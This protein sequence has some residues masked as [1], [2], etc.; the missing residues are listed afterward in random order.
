MSEPFIFI[1]TNRIKEGKLEVFKQHHE[2][3]VELVEANEPR[4]LVF[5]NYLSED[6]T[7]A[8]N[9]QVHPDADSMEFHMQV[10][11][12]H[13]REAYEFLETDN[14]QVYGTPSDSVLEMMKQ[15]AGSG[16]P[17][18]VKSQHVGGF[19]RLKSG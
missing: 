9:V 3:L 14:I 18:S 8:V 1:G 16:V 13:I 6:G 10:I 7:E 12:E 5:E 19:I 11:G 15:I 17:L 4:L 2:K